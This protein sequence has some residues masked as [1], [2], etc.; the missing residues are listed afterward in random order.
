MNAELRKAAKKYF[1]KD[2]FKLMSKAVFREKNYGESNETQ[3]YQ[4]CNNWSKKGLFGSRT[5]LSYNNFVFGRFVCNKNVE[6]RCS[7]E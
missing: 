4:A 7:H 6:N 2:F 1:K 3:R 5:K